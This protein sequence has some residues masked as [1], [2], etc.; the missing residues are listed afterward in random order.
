MSVANNKIVTMQFALV[1]IHACY[2]CNLVIIWSINIRL[3][4]MANP[5]RP[6]KCVYLAIVS[7]RG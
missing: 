7:I 3:V 5:S 6:E 4:A 1:N 2:M